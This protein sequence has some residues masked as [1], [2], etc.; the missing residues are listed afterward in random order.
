MP[1]KRN[2]AGPP[3]VMMWAKA[4]LVL[5]V[6][7]I[8]DALRYFFVFFWLAGPAMIG[9][10]CTAKVGDTAV[11]GGLLTAGCAAGATAVG[12]GGAA[13]FVALGSVMAIAT[14]F[15]GWLAVNGLILMTN[16]RAFKENPLAV[17]WSFE[18]L[19]AFLLVMVWGVY[20]DQIKREQ[21]AFKK[22]QEE[23]AA[24]QAQERNRQAAYLM[25]A[26]ATQLAQDEIY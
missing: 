4:S 3:P 13:A 11:I 25:Q 8:F 20:R 14:A 18:G 9:L 24:Q 12:I 23:T 21:A 2:N 6:A 15:T 5:V 22:Y 1:Q 26:R 16:S 19:G 10:Y 17:L 7:G